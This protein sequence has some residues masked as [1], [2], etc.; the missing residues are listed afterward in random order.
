MISLVL[1]LNRCGF[2][3]L[4]TPAALLAGA[5]AVNLLAVTDGDAPGTNA[6]QSTVQ[7]PGGSRLRVEALDAHLVRVWLKPAGEFTRQPSLALEAVPPARIPLTI[8]ES[9]RTVTVGTGALLVRIDRRTLRFEVA[10]ADG[11]LLMADARVAMTTPGAAWTLTHALDAEEKLFGL[12]QDNQNNGRL[13]RRGVIRELWA[14]Q[15]INSG[16]VTAEYPIPFL[17][18]TGRQGHAFG[19]FF[20]NVYRL[21]FD[22]AKT[23]ADE[24]RCDAEGG[25][26]D[27]YVID[28][29]KL[30]DVIERYTSLTGRPSLPPLWALG[31]WQSKCQYNNW[32]D[33]D[34]AFRQLNSRGFPVDVMV[35]D[36]GWPE[37][38]TDYVWAKRWS[39]PNDTPADKI[40]AYLQRGVKI[41]MSQSGPMVRQESPTFASGWAAGVF[42]TDGQ[43]QPVECGYYGGKLLD[44]T[45]PHINDWL[46]PQ[47]RRLNEQGT[48]GWWLDLTEPEGEPPQ[49]HYQGGRPANVHNQ[50]SLLCTQSFEGVQLAVHPDQRPFILT[51]TGSAGLQCHHAA[52]W[53]GDIYSD[54]ATLRAHPPEMLNSGL[55]GFNW[56]TC[57]TGG[58]LTGYYKNDEFGAHARLY[59]R[60][61][62]FSVFSPMTRAHKAG[63][64]PEPYQFGPAVEQSTRH[65]LQLRYRLLPYIYSYAWEASQDGLPLMRP[66]ALEFPDDPQSVATPGDEYL[67]GR[68]LLVAPVL[69]EG[70]TNR[71]VYFPPGKW[72]DWDYGYE[73]AGGREWVVAAPPNRIPVAVRAGAIIP[74]APDMMNTGEKPWDPL[75]L[76]VF[77]SGASG[78]TL[79]RDDGASFGYC[80]G[81]YTVTH[82]AAEA[83]GHSVR[84]T[85]DESN[86]RFAPSS[87]CLRLHL[88]QNPASV[89][90]AGAAAPRT[91][92]GEVAAGEW[93]WD[94]EDRVLTMA[95]DARG[96]TS[97]VINVILDDHILPVR[98]APELHADVVDSRSE[99]AGSMGKPIPHFFPPPALPTRI[100]AINYDEGGEGVAF[101]CLRPPP[102]KKRY[103][104][105]DIGLADTSDIGGGY[106]LA[107]LRPGEWVRY[108]VDCR[109]GGYFDLTVRVASGR[110]SGRIRLMALDQVVAIIDVPATGNDDAFKDVNIPAV[111]LNPGELSLLLYVDAPGFALNSFEFR[112]SAHPPSVYPAALGARTGVTELADLDGGSTG[113]GILRNLGRIGSSVTFGVVSDREGETILRFRYQGAAGKALPFSL[114]VG[115]A[116][117]KPL[118]IASTNGEWKTFDVPVLLQPGANRVNLAGLVD[119]WDSI[120]LDSLEVVTH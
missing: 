105:D 119:G 57:D 113:R 97:H 48:A 68:E 55:S 13:N 86:K 29:P 34:E 81:E 115:D 83:T 5:M 23:K 109:G 21:R 96:A 50:Y 74:L 16:N 73:Y 14:G 32:D 61:M 76:E 47:T 10:A 12:G 20:D 22:L 93:S 4:S 95:L 92:V 71:K 70:Q 44:F 87:Y 104:P 118:Q 84:L 65:Y 101:H 17:L 24:V 85:I 38:V 106:V 8:A 2:L 91:R 27:L 52:V 90:L 15:K 99:A 33:V 98:L 40:A 110:G 77:P 102:D 37:V 66:L 89:Q 82:I 67:F 31:Y 11:T 19:V 63:G 53:T 51:R 58:F 75:T 80:R 9:D 100:K 60:W 72:I 69:F 35:I 39:G 64:S 114:R 3:R 120:A 26:I 46:W 7:S 88:G 59:E 36:A 108:T 43:G 103:R 116:A 28:G 62:Q 117:E 78:F 18:S 49:T 25:E 45:N 112:P 30:S 54:Y 79:Y 41:V 94:A 111:Y 56:W 42:A 107:G 6:R 1:S